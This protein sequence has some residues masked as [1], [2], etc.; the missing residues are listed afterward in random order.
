MESCQPS[1]INPTDAAP[2][3]VILLVKS[4]TYRAGPF[5]KAA[6]RLGLEVIRGIDIDP[7]LAEQW[8]VTLPL[9]FDLPDQAAGRSPGW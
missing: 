9:Q 7:K 6:E 4:T 3:R 1:A 5:L 2:P 8:Q